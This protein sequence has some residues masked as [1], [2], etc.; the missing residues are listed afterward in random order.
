[1]FKASLCNPASKT[2]VCFR[3]SFKGAGFVVPDFFVAW[4]V[5]RS[6]TKGLF[7]GV[8]VAAAAAAAAAAV[9]VVVVV[10]AVAVAVVVVVPYNL[11]PKGVV[12]WARCGQSSTIS[13]AGAC[14]LAKS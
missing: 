6:K 4:G 10:V 3:H 1:M 11:L 5:R 9:V 13:V 7:V 2:L 8:V 12:A 14:S